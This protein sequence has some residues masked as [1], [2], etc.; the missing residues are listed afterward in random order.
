MVKRLEL[1]NEQSCLNLSAEDE[2]VFVLCARDPL[3][4]DLVEKWADL[5]EAIGKRPEK[6]AEA[7]N[8]AAEKRRWYDEATHV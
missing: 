6:I 7:R 5:A 8:C 3:A 2:M 1:Q 4:P